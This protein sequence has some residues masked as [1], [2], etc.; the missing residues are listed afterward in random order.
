MLVTVL[1]FVISLVCSQDQAT[2]VYFEFS[3]TFDII[4]HV[5][6]L[7]KHNNYGL[8]HLDWF[9]SYLTNRHTSVCI[10]CALSSPFAVLLS[11][12]QGLVLGPLLFNI[13]IDGL[14]DVPN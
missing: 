12:P 14:Y 6:V 7:H 1:D 11:I 10:S 13:F 3:N 5:L 2:S 8:S 4:P 9:C